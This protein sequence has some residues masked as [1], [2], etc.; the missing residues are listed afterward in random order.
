MTTPTL[1]PGSQFTDER[2]NLNFFNALDMKKVVRFYEIVPI[3]TKILRAWQAHREEAKWFY[4]QSGSFK[5]H[6][7]KVD[8]FDSPSSSLLPETY[9]LTAREP[10]VLYVPGGYANGFR[11]LEKDSRLQ[12]FSNF[13]LEESKGDDFRFP[14]GQWKVDWDSPRT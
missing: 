13:G 10:A 14:V 6:F 8:Y 4:C 12:I 5:V 1:I 7:I 11:A 2:A 3:S 9:I